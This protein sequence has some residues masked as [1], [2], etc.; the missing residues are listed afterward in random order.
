VKTGHVAE[1]AAKPTSAARESNVVDI[2]SLLKR[3][4]E[5]RKESRSSA[6]GD[7]RGKSPA[8]A[9]EGGAE[10]PDAA[11]SKHGARKRKAG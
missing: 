1:V 3:S 8:L 10:K 11:K 6:G 5:E 9:T 7:S 4:M 2:M